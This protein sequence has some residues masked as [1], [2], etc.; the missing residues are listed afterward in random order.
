MRSAAPG[1][2]TGL[3]PGPRRNANQGA[4]LQQNPVDR[5]LDPQER[6]RCKGRTPPGT[7]ASR[8]HQQ[9]Q[10]AHLPQ[11]GVLPATTPGT[12][13]S[14]TPA[15]VKVHQ[16]LMLVEQ[17]PATGIQ[18]LGPMPDTRER[19]LLPGTAGV[20]ALP[21][22]GRCATAAWRRWA[23]GQAALLGTARC[24][25]RRGTV[26]SAGPARRPRACGRPVVITGTDRRA[27]HPGTAR[28]DAAP[29]GPRACERPAVP[30]KRPVVPETDRR[31]AAK[32][33]PRTH[34]RPIKRPRLDCRPPGGLRA[35]RRVRPPG[36]A[37]ASCPCR[38]VGRWS[39]SVAFAGPPQRRSAGRKVRSRTAC[40]VQ[41][42]ILNNVKKDKAIPHP[43][44]DL[45]VWPYTRT[46]GSH[47]GP[48]Q[49]C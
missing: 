7:P 49:K 2:R 5:R 45:P 9:C 8:R 35:D 47:H 41:A 32:R 4:F 37:N 13:G 36:V 33:V 42:L 19:V 24:S 11:I 16:P 34:G 14:Q 25:A 30:E 48:A 28:G 38:V 22:T 31:Q 1:G 3:T 29:R 10:Q 12:A 39:P 17:P 23:N 27:A 40:P 26:P 44:V 46:P 18:R 6:I 21:G 43:P 15:E 20:N